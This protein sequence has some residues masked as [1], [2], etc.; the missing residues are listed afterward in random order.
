MDAVAAASG[1]K[2]EILLSDYQSPAFDIAALDL[3]FELFADYTKVV[4]TSRYAM[5]QGAGHDLRLD[6]GPFME[7]TGIR[8]NGA[9]L[10]RGDYRLED[11]SLTILAVPETFELTIETVLKPKENTRLEG[12]YYSGGNFCTQCEAEGFRHITYFP[13]RPDV[14]TRYN[15]RIEADKVS[16]PVLL[17]NGNP[18]ASGDLSDKRHYAEWEDPFPKP[19]YLFALVAGD[20]ACLSDSFTTQS[21]REIALN[22]YVAETDLDKCGHAM[23]SLK[24]SMSWDEVTFGLEYDLDIYNIVAVSDFNM[25]AME[26]KGLNVFNT[27]CVLASPE[28]ATDSDFDIVEGVIGHEYFHNWTGNRVT[29]RD[30]FQLSLKEGLTVFRDQEFSSDMGSRGVKRLD[31]V[32][33]LRMLQFPEDAGPLAHPVRPEKYIEINNFYTTTV[34]N[35]GAEVIRMMHR[36]IGAAAFRKGMDLY[37]ERH[38]GQA[39]TC[40]DFVAAMEDASGADLKQFRHWYSQ[41]G[42]PVV[43]VSR[44]K[45]GADVLLSIEQTCPATP[46]QAV[47]KPF[48]MPLLVGW[49]D[50]E[51]AQVM[52]EC[53]DVGARWTEEGCLLELTEDRMKFRFR[54]VVDGAVPSLLRA[55][56]A[57][58]ILN[59]DLTLDELAFLVKADTDAFAR[60]EAAQHLFADHIIAVS[61]ARVSGAKVPDMLLDTFRQLLDDENCDQALLAELLTLPSEIA[62]GQR[63]DCLL[64]QEIH[65]AREALSDALAAASAQ[66]ILK[67]YDHLAASGYSLAPTAKAQRRLRNVLLGYIARLPQGEGIVGRHFVDADN[68]TDRMAALALVAHS[69]FGSRQELLSRFYDQWRHNDLVIDKWFAVQAQSKRVDTVHMVKALTDHDAFT[70]QNPNRLRSLVSSFAMMNQARFHDAS[71]DGYQ[72]L[73]DMIIS[74]DKVNPQ[75][76]ARLVAPLGR[77]NRVDDT[78]R[79]LMQ[80]ALH[81]I[82]TAP[83]LSDDVRELVEKSLA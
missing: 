23:A 76:A 82:K 31:D 16:C 57:P 48:H 49:L 70:L 24:R 61:E 29:C 7:L 32:R 71:G 67:R 52:P 37:F 65:A 79:Q 17:S 80:K 75:T 33:L 78:R 62:V 15:V 21:G 13:D 41:S 50:A 59:H 28:T 6:G 40:E 5:R 19:C 54:N 18:V 25:G 36:M 2:Q 43:S 46:G 81:D 42:T 56:S 8:L 74:V 34:Y 4:A 45:D 22:I 10:E 73:S 58:I 69:D 35:K 55:F 27:K 83:G 68:M 51:G 53:S 77:W 66:A 60:W 64:P 26:N 20:L 72:F 12:L 1:P 38:D 9:A 3:R 11:D 63:M 47:K 39:V 44:E 30:W 14:L